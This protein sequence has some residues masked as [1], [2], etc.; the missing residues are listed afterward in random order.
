MERLA[1]RHGPLDLEGFRNM[2]IIPELLMAGAFIVAAI[3]I[4][5]ILSHS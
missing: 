2:K 1:R 4:S 5:D 3:V